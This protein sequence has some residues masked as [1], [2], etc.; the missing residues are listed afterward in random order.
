MMLYFQETFLRADFSL[1]F[2]SAIS[3]RR[4]EYTLQNVM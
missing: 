1:F 3:D 4:V 2:A